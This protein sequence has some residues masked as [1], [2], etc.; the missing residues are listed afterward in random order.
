MISL[1]SLTGGVECMSALGLH[2]LKIQLL[3][4]HHALHDA[5]SPAHM[6]PLQHAACTTLSTRTI[7]PNTRIGSERW[8]DHCTVS[9][10]CLCPRPVELRPMSSKST[11]CQWQGPLVVC[12]AAAALASVT[13]GIDSVAASSMSPSRAWLDPA[14]LPRL[15][16]DHPHLKWCEH[17]DDKHEPVWDTGH[18]GTSSFTAL[19]S[20]A[21]ASYWQ[22]KPVWSTVCDA[23]PVSA[24]QATFLGRRKLREC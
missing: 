10:Y 22:T 1:A 24:A 20:F 13:G 11:R 12:V 3:I 8:V 16:A 18:K 15:A 21:P 6:H 9:V 7:F 19:N 2:G 5:C 17:Y 23:L 4:A 14:S